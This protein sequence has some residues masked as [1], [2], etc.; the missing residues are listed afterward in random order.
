MEPNSN[1]AGVSAFS[2]RLANS[3]KVAS[4]TILLLEF[5]MFYSTLG[6]GL[7]YNDAFFRL[8]VLVPTLAILA[9]LCAVWVVVK[10]RQAAW[11]VVP[12]LALAL[13]TYCIY[14]VALVSH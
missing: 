11:L 1:L 14:P 7:A 8:L 12:V 2:Q 10:T 5:W 4:F 3:L 9:A 6:N 13:G